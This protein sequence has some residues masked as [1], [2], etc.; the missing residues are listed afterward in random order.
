MAR[1]DDTFFESDDYREGEAGVVNVFLHDP[2]Y[3]LM[4]ED[5]ER[6]ETAF[7]WG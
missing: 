6:N 3:R 7:D 5:L 1:P 4:V 2:E